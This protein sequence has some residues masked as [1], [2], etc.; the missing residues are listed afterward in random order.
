MIIDVEY[1]LDKVNSLMAILSIVFSDVSRICGMKDD[2]YQIKFE[3]DSYKESISKGISM[4]SDYFDK[5]KSRTIDS[6]DFQDP[7]Y[8]MNVNLKN[9]SCSI[10]A[11]KTLSSILNR[12]KQISNKDEF[13]IVLIASDFEINTYIDIYEL[14]NKYLRLIDGIDIVIVGNE[15][16]FSIALDSYL[17]HKNGFKNEG[18]GSSLV[19]KLIR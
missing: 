9:V 10:N 14:C 2:S 4:D 6:N 17:T 19:S 11:V 16:I 12:Y 7:E 13:K 3:F 18:L 1:I 15:K 5:K 8:L